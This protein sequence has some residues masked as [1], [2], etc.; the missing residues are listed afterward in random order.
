MR[1]IPKNKAKYALPVKKVE[2]VRFRQYYNYT[3]N[4]NDGGTVYKFIG[5]KKLRC[6][7]DGVWEGQVECAR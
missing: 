5:D 1:D 6:G 4:N 2:S 3:C 7:L